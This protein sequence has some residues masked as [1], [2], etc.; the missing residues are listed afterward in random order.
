MEALKGIKYINTINSKLLKVEP[1]L[2]RKCTKDIKMLLN[3]K[4]VPI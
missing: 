3:N 4:Y 2:N 1:T